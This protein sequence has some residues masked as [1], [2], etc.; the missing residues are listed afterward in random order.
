[1]LPE[2]NRP[3]PRKALREEILAG[4]RISL[5]AGLGMV[6]LGIAFGLLVIQLG[7]PWWLAPALSIAIYAGS[8]ELLLLGL[9]TS[10][11]PL[12]T[13]A[14]TTFLVNFRHVFYAFTFPLQVMKNPAAKA[15]S[16]YALTDE[17]FAVT[18]AFPK[19][20]TEPRLL[21]T[22][23]AFQLYWVGGGLIGIGVGTMLPGPIAGL[24]FALCALFISL[25]LD[26]ART[27][28]EIPS[29]LLAGLSFTFA[30]VIA[31]DALLFVALLIFM[32]TLV[33]RY[34]LAPPKQKEQ[35]GA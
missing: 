27:K 11:A 18:A 34:L 3:A 20:W 31:P 33:L 35:T 10:V 8:V 17:S 6:P 12:M 16:V 7:L 26:A 14:L 13:I 23:I 19:G 9:V 2:R 15:Y 29:L 1:M 24:E 22:Q 30:A 21:T 28:A 4:L 32:G 5:P 25:T